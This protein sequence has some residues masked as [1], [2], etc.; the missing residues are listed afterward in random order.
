MLKVTNEAIAVEIAEESHLWFKQGDIEG[1]FEWGDLKAADNATTLMLRDRI[2]KFT[3]DLTELL[4]VALMEQRQL[5]LEGPLSLE[6]R[7][8]R[9]YPGKDH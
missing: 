2:V 5:S 3:E 6:G 7:Q 8:D 1:F 4:Q 9:T